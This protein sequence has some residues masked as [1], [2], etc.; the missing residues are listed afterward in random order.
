M[1]PPDVPIPDITL[2]FVEARDGRPT[3]HCTRV[4]YIGGKKVSEEELE[5]PVDQLLA[6]GKR[7][8]E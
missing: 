5:L 8:S 7:Q 2:L 3:G 1:V 4:K 6:R